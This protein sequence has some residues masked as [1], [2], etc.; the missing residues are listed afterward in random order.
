MFIAASLL[1][2]DPV[3]PFLR[4]AKVSYQMLLMLTKVFR[5]SFSIY[6]V[7]HVMLC[8]QG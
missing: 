7:M 8:I 1:T 5:F 6:H 4:V 3:D 2:S